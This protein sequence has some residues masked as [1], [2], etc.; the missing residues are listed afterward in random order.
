MSQSASEYVNLPILYYGGVSVI[1]LEAV[2]RGSDESRALDVRQTASGE[3]LRQVPRAE[4][5]R[6]LARSHGTRCR[7]WSTSI[8][9][10]I[11]N[12]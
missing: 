3:T 8:R 9:S 5:S 2:A 6:V 4:F 12:Y 7:P 11:G 1:R 10:N